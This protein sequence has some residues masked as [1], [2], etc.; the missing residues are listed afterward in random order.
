MKTMCACVMFVA[1]ASAGCGSGLGSVFAGEAGFGN[2]VNGAG[3]FLPLPIAGE[4]GQDGVDGVD[5]ADGVDGRTGADGAQG[6]QGPPGAAGVDG[7]AG[8]AGQA[9]PPG[10]DGACDCTHG[11][12]THAIIDDPG[13]PH[14]Q[15]TGPAIPCDRIE[16]WDGELE[17]VGG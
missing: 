14:D 10:P 16:E 1:L 2:F 5:G 13:N 11:C 4:D 9:G 12:H 15:V 6:D 8:Q 7:S 3:L 17:R